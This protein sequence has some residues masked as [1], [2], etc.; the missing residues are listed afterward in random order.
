MRNVFSL[1]FIVELL[2]TWEVWRVL[3]YSARVAGSRLMHASTNSCIYRLYIYT[4]YILYT[5]SSLPN[6]H[7]IYNSKSTPIMKHLQDFI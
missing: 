5:L 7:V 2:S 6:M 4:L 1:N 3:N